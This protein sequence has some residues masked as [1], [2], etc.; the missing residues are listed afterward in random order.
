MQENPITRLVIATLEMSDGSQIQIVHNL[1]P[2][3]GD[4]LIER[5]RRKSRHHTAMNLVYWIKERR[6]YCICVTK[7]QYDQTIRK[8]EAETGKSAYSPATKEEYE[9]QERERL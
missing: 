4:R 3:T 5:W 1:D 7:E 6:P 9:Q 2:D 8:Y